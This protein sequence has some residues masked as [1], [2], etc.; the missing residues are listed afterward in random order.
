MKFRTK[1][2]H[3]GSEANFKAGA[4]G[5]VV[6]PIHLSTTFA[7]KQVNKLTAGFDYSRSGNPTR[8]AL[9]KNLAALE[10]GKYG[11]A[12][13]SGMAAITNVMFLFKPGDH[14]IAIDNLYGGTHRLFTE[15]FTQWGITFSLVDFANGDELKSHIRKNTKLIWLESPT[16]PLLKIIDLSSVARLAKQK[17]ITTV[18]DNTFATPYLQT[19]L[20]LG[21]DI[22]VH[23]ATK[24]LGGHSDVI[25]GCVVTKNPQ[26]GKRLSFLQNA[27]G[28]ILSPFDSYT[29]LRGIKTLS[30]RM[31]E[32]IKNAGLIASF[33]SN[34][35]KVKRVYYPGLKSHKGYA[36]AKA[37]MKGFGGIVSFELKGTMAATVKFLQSLKIISLAV[38]LGAVESLIEHPATMT[39]FELSKQEREKIGISDTLIRLSVGIEDANDLIADLSQALEKI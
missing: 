1:A 31:D 36:V 11:L 29:L 30:V 7:Q 6:I 15:I 34:H 18:I 37:Q 17:N 20:D 12:F 21:I 28:A 23:S 13:S 9:E 38:S 16:N 10:N 32:H 39:H 5:D 35:K 14:I 25:A 19:P 33:L 27:I 3:I 26:L 4:S 24:Y 8:A 22:V 2:I